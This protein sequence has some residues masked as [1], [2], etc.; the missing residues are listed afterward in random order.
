MLSCATRGYGTSAAEAW[1]L[2]SGVVRRFF[3]DLYAVR[4]RAKFLPMKKAKTDMIGGAYLWASRK[5][6]V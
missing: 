6:T 5:L 1:H 2:V 4:G 3:G